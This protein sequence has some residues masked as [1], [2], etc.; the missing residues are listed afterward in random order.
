MNS[1]GRTVTGFLLATAVI[2]STASMSPAQ[3]SPIKNIDGVA[4]SI[5]GGSVHSQEKKLTVSVIGTY[6]YYRIVRKHTKKFWGVRVSAQHCGYHKC[7]GKPVHGKLGVGHPIG[8]ALSTASTR[9]PIPK[10]CSIGG[11][12]IKPWDWAKKAASGVATASS[13]IG[14]ADEML[15]LK[16]IIPCML[17]T[18][19]GWG[20][21]AAEQVGRRFA[22]LGGFMTRAHYAA[23][24]AGPEGYVVAGFSG[25]AIG[26]ATAGGYQLWQLRRHL[27]IQ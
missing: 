5:T 21:T 16:L 1:V 7:W 3:A 6:S 8:K 23:G 13:W 12:D 18:G 2:V 20:K 22:L 11:L 17:G 10:C 25:C 27:G 24:I 9:A 14:H 15:Q 4:G 26:F 19:T